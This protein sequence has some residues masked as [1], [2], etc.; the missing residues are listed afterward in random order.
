MIKLLVIDDEALEGEAIRCLLQ[1]HRPYIKMVGQA[2]S[3]RAGLDLTVRT[4]PDIVFMDIQMP[5]L[6]G[7]I[8][9]K[10][11]KQIYPDIKVV[12]ISAYDDSEFVLSAIKMGASDYLLKPVRPQE[13]LRVLDSLYDPAK[14]PNDLGGDIIESGYKLIRS[15]KDYIEKNYM[16]NIT[17]EDVAKEISISPFYFSRLFKEKQGINFIDYLIEL[18]IEKAK[19]MLINTDI[20]V[21]E[22]AK[23]VAYSEANSFSRLF[24]SREGVSPSEYRRINQTLLQRNF[25]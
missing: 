21:K 4:K 3:G 9:T 15:A 16:H 7:I 11:I 17:L 12:M 2:I 22:I 25:S 14:I 18:R 13:I 1:Q 23:N 10:F 24:K 5:G 6:D 19:Q 20:S 8:T